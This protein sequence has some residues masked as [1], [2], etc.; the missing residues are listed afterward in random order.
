MI[1]NSEFESGGT[2]SPGPE[3]RRR[4]GLGNGSSGAKYST[5]SVATRTAPFPNKP[6]QERLQK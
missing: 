4:C 3:K 2:Q 1:S 6:L 5:T